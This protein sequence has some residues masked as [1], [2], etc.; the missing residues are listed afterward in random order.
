MFK[1][2]VRRV[3]LKSNLKFR[4]ETQIGRGRFVALFAKRKWKGA[5][6]F[7]RRDENSGRDQSKTSRRAN[8]AATT[9]EK[10]LFRAWKGF[11]FL[12]IYGELSRAI[13]RG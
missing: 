7:A 3:N 1:T 9:F 8:I 4:L 11:F 5:H 10:N 12:Y 2:S 6:F 13:S